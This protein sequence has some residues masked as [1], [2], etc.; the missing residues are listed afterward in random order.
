[1]LSKYY[2]KL[3]ESKYTP[4]DKQSINFE[5]CVDG[6]NKPYAERLVQ[7]LLGY[8]D[9]DGANTDTEGLNH[10]N[11]GNGLEVQTGLTTKLVPIQPSSESDGD[12]HTS[13]S[14]QDMRP[15]MH[16]YQNP[17]KLSQVSAMPGLR[18]KISVIIVGAF[19]W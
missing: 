17:S 3:K 9:I 10:D 6:K 16:T 1:M 12:Y 15:R 19:Y 4:V 2:K 14:Q 8:N 7:Y 13:T 18:C 11:K 5:T